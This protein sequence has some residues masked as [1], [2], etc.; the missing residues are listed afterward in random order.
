MKRLFYMILIT[1][2]CAGLLGCDYGA[3][4]LSES[5]TSDLQTGESTES[6]ETTD[7]ADSAESS[8]VT[9]RVESTESSEVTDKVES[10]ESEEP[11]DGTDS[12]GETV[13]A[14]TETGTQGG[15]EDGETTADSDVFFAPDFTVYDRNGNPVRLSDF[16]GKPVVL[17]FWATWCGPCQREMPD[18]QKLYLELGTEVQFLMIN[19]TD[20]TYDTV[21]GVSAFLTE[22]GYT[23]PVFFDTASNAANTYGVESIPT[24]YFINAEG[25]LVV[26]AV[27]TLNEATLRQG[28]G[29]IR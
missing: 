17:N 23:F 22:Q 9:D 10:T 28:I 14:E 16:R 1:A 5:L 12:V 4:E 7:E 15:T 24:T 18:F 8:E 3:G 13:E 20:G 25:V 11:A 6:V 27:G 19:L 26:R 2:L 21:A 29:M